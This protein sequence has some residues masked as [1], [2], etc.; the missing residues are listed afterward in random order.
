MEKCLEAKSNHPQ[1][2]KKGFLSEVHIRSIVL[3]DC[4]IVVYSWLVMRR[5][6]T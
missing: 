5:L 3:V 2:V 4:S 1:W 6:V